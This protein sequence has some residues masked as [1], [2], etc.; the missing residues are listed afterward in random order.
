MEINKEQLIVDY[1]SGLSIMKIAKK[2][3]ISCTPIAKKMKEFG[4]KARPSNQANFGKKFS[5][6]H[7]KK[8]SNAKK[9]NKNPNFGKKCKRKGR[10]WYVCPD[11][12]TVSMRSLWEIWY[13]EYLRMN[14][15][16][17]KYEPTTFIL[18][19]GVAY[20]PD[21][22]LDTGE[23]VEVKG[24]LTEEHKIKMQMFKETYPEK[25]L[26]L[27]NKKYLLNLGIDLRKKWIA[28]KPLF[29]CEKC[30][31]LFNRSYPSQRFCSI[32]CRNKSTAATRN[33]S[34][35]AIPVKTKRKYNGNQ[36]GENSN[37]TK[38]KEQDIIS[39]HE[40]RESGSTLKSISISKNIS[41][42][43]ISN[44]LLGKSWKYIYER[45]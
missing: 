12:K 36:S 44:I 20:T 4:I 43:T 28:T 35:K 8:I 14:N 18:K 45:R 41:I 31:N 7:R 39:I 2:Y 10:H 16:E 5:E 37:C 9:G 19:D 6:E 21:F 32:S 17:F 30:E 1:A 22:L 23:Y 42:S 3:G 38:L 25:T 13:A 34:V 24:W 40:M 29:A 26:I 15:V 27:A 33:K 11:G